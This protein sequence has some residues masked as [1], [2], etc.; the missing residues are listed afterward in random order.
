MII[1]ST[2][3]TTPLEIHVLLLHQLIRI[4]IS[5]KTYS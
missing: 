3:Y 5:A 1:Y 2:G 4:K